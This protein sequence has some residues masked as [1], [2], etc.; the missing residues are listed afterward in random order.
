M[1]GSRCHK[2]TMI[3]FCGVCLLD[4]KIIQLP[5]MGQVAFYPSTTTSVSL[6]SAE[7]KLEGTGV[8]RNRGSNPDSTA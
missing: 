7:R 4:N 3:E 8:R 5:R 1:Q 2:P 6:C